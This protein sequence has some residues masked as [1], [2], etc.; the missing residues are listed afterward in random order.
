[1]KKEY[2]RIYWVA[3]AHTGHT[4]PCQP[5]G[6]YTL[7]EAINRVCREVEENNRIGL[8]DHETDYIIYDTSA[9]YWTT[10]EF[11]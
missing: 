9:K 11:W 8:E 4:L 1:M 6:K 7:R 2:R 3:D 10:V 5:E